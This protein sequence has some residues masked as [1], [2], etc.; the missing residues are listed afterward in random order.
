MALQLTEVEGTGT[1]Q[2]VLSKRMVT[3]QSP[4][5]GDANTTSAERNTVYQGRTFTDTVLTAYMS[6]R[7]S[8]VATPTDQGP[9]CS[10]SRVRDR[11][12]GN[13]RTLHY[14]HQVLP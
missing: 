8:F 14:M 3:T 5:Q 9:W 12:N 7:E 1:Y 13:Q 11:R 4:S 2:H 10:R 6:C